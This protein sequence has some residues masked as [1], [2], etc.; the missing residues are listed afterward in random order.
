MRKIINHIKS[1]WYR[2]GLETLVVIFGILVDLRLTI[3]IRT[4]RVLKLNYLLLI[5]FLLS[6]CYSTRTIYYANNSDDIVTSDKEVRVYQKVSKNLNI[7]VKG[8]ITSTECDSITVTKFRK[9]GINKNYLIRK[10]DIQKITVRYGPNEVLDLHSR[11]KSS[12]FQIDVGGFISIGFAEVN[13]Q[14][15][16]TRPL[17][18]TG[19]LAFHFGAGGTIWAD[20][21][22]GALGIILTPALSYGRKHRFELGA[23]FR[24][25]F[26]TFFG[27][28]WTITPAKIAYRFMG[29]KATFRL[30]FAPVSLNVNHYGDSFLIGTSLSLKLNK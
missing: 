11:L 30:Y 9:S 28:Y 25:Y 26:H 1:E 24:R 27:P 3:G 19:L 20:D 5:P 18:Q 2:Y 8:K 22:D 6:G 17:D 23:D 29:K 21:I 10:D 16:L 12:D 14:Y 15:V 13:L 7:L 4:G